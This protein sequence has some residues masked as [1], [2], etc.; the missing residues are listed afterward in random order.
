MTKHR[1]QGGQIGNG[2]ACTE[3]VIVGTFDDDVAAKPV[4]Q[5]GKITIHIL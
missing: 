2:S 3:S 5:A 1:Q 4:H